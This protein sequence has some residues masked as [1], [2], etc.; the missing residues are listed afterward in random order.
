M[1]TATGIS[2]IHNH[3]AFCTTYYVM[4]LAYNTIPM[5]LPSQ[6]FC[7]AAIN[8][9][10]NT[11][12]YP[13]PGFELPF[14]VFRCI[15]ALSHGPASMSNDPET[16]PYMDGC[17]SQ[18]ANKLQTPPG[19]TATI[20]QDEH[21]TLAHNDTPALHTTHGQRHISRIQRPRHRG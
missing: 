2:C 14:C 20:I 15:L 12:C 8:S 10:S 18:N 19:A 7:V 17:V 3:A 4:L 16:T 21:S 5:H 9:V 1:P 6:V 11:S 13:S